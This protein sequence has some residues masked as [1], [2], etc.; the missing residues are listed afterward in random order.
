MG[1]DRDAYWRECFEIS[2]DEAG[3]GHLLAQ[4]TPEQIAD[5][6]GGIQGGSE[7]IGMAFYVP[8]NPM[9]REN[10]RLSAK[11]RWEREL[12]PCNPCNGSGRLRYN[13]GPWA[14]NAHCDACNGAGKVHPRGVRAPC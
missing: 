4:M 1:Y 11:L 3:C 12:W 2:M 5:V 8:E 6:A 10:E 7:N 14:V 13:A 9:I